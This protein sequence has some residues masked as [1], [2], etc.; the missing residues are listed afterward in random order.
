MQC[1]LKLNLSFRLSVKRRVLHIRVI[2]IFKSHFVPRK[3]KTSSWQ[4]FWVCHSSTS[5][6]TWLG[7]DSWWHVSGD[8]IWAAVSS[9]F[10][11]LIQTSDGYIHTSGDYI[12]TADS[13]WN[14][15]SQGNKII[16][17]YQSTYCGS[18]ITSDR[19]QT[20]M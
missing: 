8:R 20:F 13:K 11:N 18:V 16:P 7:L 6:I 10:I 12:Q 15:R 1:Y 2:Y 9:Y 19:I 17:N 14:A 3:R 5:D 4:W